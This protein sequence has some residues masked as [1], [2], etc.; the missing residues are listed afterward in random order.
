MKAV[1]TRYGTVSLELQGEG[2]KSATV[3]LCI[4]GSTFGSFTMGLNEF[5]D[6]MRAVSLFD[7]GIQQSFVG[8]DS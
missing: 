7:R 8:A 2:P 3:D 5:E 1:N 4:D 6:L